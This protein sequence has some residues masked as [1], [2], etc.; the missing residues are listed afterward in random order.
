MTENYMKLLDFT[1]IIYNFKSHNF[2]VLVA[3]NIIEKVQ[4]L[5]ESIRESQSRKKYSQYPQLN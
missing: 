1:S 4:L 3:Y 5:R 2:V